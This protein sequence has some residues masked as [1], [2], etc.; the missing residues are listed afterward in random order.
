M[1]VGMVF[2]DLALTIDRPAPEGDT[3]VECEGFDDLQ[4][5]WAYEPNS[6]PRRWLG[7][8]HDRHGQSL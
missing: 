5:A 4:A 1:N 3:R 7:V 2:S 8:Q 6:H